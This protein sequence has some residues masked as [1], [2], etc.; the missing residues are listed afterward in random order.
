MSLAR[1][2][3][4][5][6]MSERSARSTLQRGRVAGPATAYGF[7]LMRV[8]QDAANTA[9]PLP[10]AAAVVTPTATRRLVVHWSDD[11]TLLDLVGDAP[12]DLGAVA[13]RAMR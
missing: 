2:V 10:G 4:G 1:D 12:S 13:R 7:P 8:R 3:Y 6:S 5:P 9:P 11:R